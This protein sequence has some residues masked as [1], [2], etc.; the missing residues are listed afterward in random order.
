MNPCSDHVLEIYPSTSDGEFDA[1]SIRFTTE[2]PTPNPPSD[3]DV[4]INTLTNKV[5][6]SWSKV[7]CATGYKIHQ[8]LEHSD[9]ETEWTSDNMQ[10]L[11]VS[12]ESPEPCV[13]YRYKD[14]I[15][16]ALE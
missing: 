9:T 4:T 2:N 15:Q 8:K 6:I 1:E 3:I 12:L 11:S 5:D 14:M 16:I 7:E 10:D 13:T